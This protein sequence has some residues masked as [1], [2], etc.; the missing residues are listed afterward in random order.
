MTT[1]CEATAC[2]RTCEEPK[3]FCDVCWGRLPMEL[4]EGLC[5]TFDADLGRQPG[6]F[7]LML[8]RCAGFLKARYSGRG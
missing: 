8:Y 2:P 7:T 1:V 5:D 6:S 4:R 3:R